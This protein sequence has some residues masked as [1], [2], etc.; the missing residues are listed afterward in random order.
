MG[1]VVRDFLVGNA[2]ASIATVFSG[3]N[4]AV[5]RTFDGNGEGGYFGHGE[6][7]DDIDG[8]GCAD[9]LLGAREKRHGRDQRRPSVPL[10]RPQRTTPAHDDAYAR[11]PSAS[12]ATRARSATST[13]TG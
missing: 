12:G 7:I 4:G 8:D 2:P 5:L 1:T 9:V 10:L 6:L 13:A 3:S 11:Q